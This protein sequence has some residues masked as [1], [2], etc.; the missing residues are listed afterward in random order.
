MAR[1]GTVPTARRST[2]FDQFAS[3]DRGPSSPA[4]GAVRFSTIVRPPLLSRVV[5]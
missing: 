4:G 5:L 1:V 2:G 3:L